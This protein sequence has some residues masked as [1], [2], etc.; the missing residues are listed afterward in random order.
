MNENK[1]I[2]KKS[3]VNIIIG[4]I[5][6]LLYLVIVGIDFYTKLINDNTCG[7]KS[8]LL[9][10]ALFTL[11]STVV[12][13][14]I[15]I[16]NKKQNLKPEKFFIVT[17]LIIGIFYLFA[18]P[19]FKG[20]D[21]QY[22][23]YKSYAVSLGEFIAVPNE[24]GVLG[25]YL[26]RMVNDVFERQGFFTGINYKT[27]I[28]SWLYSIQN[29]EI[30]EKQ[31]IYNAPT[32]IY[33]PIQMLPQAL[34]IFIA[35][36]VKLDVFTQAYFARLG[37]LI[38]FLILGYF[39]IKNLPRNKIFLVAL[40]LS[41][42]IMYISSTMS[43]DVFTNSIIILFVSYIFKLREE[44]KLLALKDYIILLITMPCVAICKTIYAPI[45]LLVLLIPKECF[46]NKFRKVIL[47]L[48]GIIIAVI[49]SLGWSKLSAVGTGVSTNPE[50]K[51]GLQMIYV[52]EHPV[53]FIGVLIRG[54]CNN[55]IS[56]TEDIVGGNMEWGAGLTQP[57]IVS[58][59]IYF[60]FAMSLANEEK[61]DKF[62][63]WEY[64]II[65]IAILVPVAG[66]M[67][68][69]YIQWTPNYADVGGLKIIGVQGRYFVPI[70]LLVA[71]IIPTKYIETKNKLD[72]KWIYIILMLCELFSIVN[73]FTNNI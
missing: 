23:W 59:I 46:K 61:K 45:C 44:K 72:T 52:L 47:T 9:F 48:I 19:M 5:M 34:G 63:V 54:V 32:A 6:Y 49:T 3:N 2:I 69:M 66:A 62:K 18:T 29:N 53:S 26:P 51:A 33:P 38:F 73:I 14:I 39:S 4:A 16:I 55:F 17:G 25:D 36:S 71:S 1:S 13:I 27:L 65:A 8:K 30:S 21:E 60:I 20:H 40:L 15:I 42:K 22:H 37:N 31:F 57:T 11:I 58:A 35:R 67:A 10:A 7:I 70:M 56:W 43:G 64:L 28:E 41:P 50:T 24:E 68:A 12:G